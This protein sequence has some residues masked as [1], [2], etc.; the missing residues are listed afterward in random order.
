MLYIIYSG[1]EVYIFLIFKF[2]IVL[3]V[4]DFPLLFCLLFYCYVAFVLLYC[5]CTKFVN[6]Q[7]TFSCK[8]DQEAL[9]QCFHGFFQT[10]GVGCWFSNFSCDIIWKRREREKRREKDWNATY[11]YNNFLIFSW[12]TVWKIWKLCLLISK[13]VNIFLIFFIVTLSIVSFVVVV[14]V[15]LRDRV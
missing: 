8:Y 2:S 12:C 7:K 14:A 11:I 5:T 6:V 1:F 3:I 15:V 4:S 13:S 9:I 10:M